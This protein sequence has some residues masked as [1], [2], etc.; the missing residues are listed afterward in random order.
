MTVNSTQVAFTAAAPYATSPA[1]VAKLAVDFQAW[2]DDQV[3]AGSIAEDVY[4]AITGASEQCDYYQSPAAILA[5]AAAT[6]T[7]IE[8]V[9]DVVV[10]DLFGLSPAA[11]D[12]AITVAQLTK[13]TGVPG[14]GL[15][16]TVLTQTLVAGAQADIG[17]EISYTYGNTPVVPP[18]PTGVS[19]TGG[20]LKST[21]T[22]TAPTDNGGAEITGYKVDQSTGNFSGWATCAGGDAV[23]ALTLIN[24]ALAIGSWKFRVSAINSAGTGLPSAISTAVP[25]V[26]VPGAPTTVAGTGGVRSTDITWVAPAVTGG[27]P[28]TGYRV[29]QRLGEDAWANLRADTGTTAVTLST[30]LGVGSWTFRV[31]AINDIGTSAASVVSDA[32]IVTADIPGAPTL[33]VGTGGVL[34]A[35][36][37]WVAPVDN[38]GSVITGYKVE[39]S[40]NDGANWATCAGGAAVNDLQLPGLILAEGSWRFRVSAINAIGTGPVSGASVAAVVTAV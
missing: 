37:T 23:N 14:A 7:L 29:E 12:S 16:N 15:R 26:S 17:D 13:G 24:V 9:N 2:I 38:G 35:G 25:V 27:H 40:S 11:A 18:V 22:W 4:A 5:C 28:I 21:I 30:A 36:V 19:A 10:P 34:G 32:V 33:V 1:L 39:E 20:T 3:I 6:L 31:S 8:A